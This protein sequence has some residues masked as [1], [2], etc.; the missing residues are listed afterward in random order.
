MKNKKLRTILIIL[1][2]L[3]GFTFL[4]IF[5]QSLKN[6]LSIPERLSPSDI[7]ENSCQ[8]SI[9]RCIIYE[10]HKY[11]NCK[12]R[13][14]ISEIY[15]QENSLNLSEIKI[16]YSNETCI[17]YSRKFLIDTGSFCESSQVESWFVQYNNSYERTHKLK[18]E[19]YNKDKKLI[20]QQ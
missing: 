3:L 6:N 16:P 1:F 18:M 11:F 7:A 5:Y 13:I 14:Y 2:I 4:N 15:K 17:D 12:G 10:D 9:L 20:W 8:N 19:C